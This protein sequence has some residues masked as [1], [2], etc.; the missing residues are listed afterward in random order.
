MAVSDSART[1]SVITGLEERD[2]HRRRVYVGVR[3]ALAF[4]LVGLVLVMAVLGP[5]ITPADPLAQDITQRLHPPAW[6]AHGQRSHLLGTD[7]L[8]RDVLSRIL[9]GARISLTVSL[10]SAALA[11]VFGVLLGLSAGF[12]RGWLDDVVMRLVEIQLAFP[13]LLLAITIMAVLRPSMRNVIFVLAISG[14]VVHARLVRGITLSL[15]Q[16]E[17]VQA[18]RA[19]GASD[20]R[21]MVR[22]ILPNLLPVMTVVLTLQVAQFIVAESALSFL[23]LGLR[24]PTPS[25]GSMMNEGREYLSLAWWIETFPGLV[26]VVATTG[27]GLLGDWLRDVLDPHLKV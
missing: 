24:P 14:W 27:I 12:Y 7:Q 16:G 10:A 18:A 26:I 4:G 8:G 15:A 25:W 9:S 13:Y 21:L 1:A 5:L 22:H 3:G 2:P 11:A 19:L 20:R 6:L 23:G 17:F